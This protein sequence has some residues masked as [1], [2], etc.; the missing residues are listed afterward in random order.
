[1]FATVW[2]RVGA[3]V[4]VSLAVDMRVE[5]VVGAVLGAAVDGAAFDDIDDIDGLVEDGLGLATSPLT[6]EPPLVM[7]S[8]LSSD[9]LRSL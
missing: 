3:W 4:A 6:Q 9:P 2:L 5:T 8:M 7:T 1:M